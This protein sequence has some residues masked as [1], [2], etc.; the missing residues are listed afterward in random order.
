M[1]VSCPFIFIHFSI[2]FCSTLCLWVFGIHFMLIHLDEELN[3]E[4][5]FELL[6]ICQGP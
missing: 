2:V 1:A 3:I 5:M 6:E 4:I